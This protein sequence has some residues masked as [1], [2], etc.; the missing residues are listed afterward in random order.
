VYGK[1]RQMSDEQRSDRIEQD[2]GEEPDRVRETAIAY[3]EPFPWADVL[4]L[5]ANLATM[6]TAD[7]L[8]KAIARFIEPFGYE[9]GPPRYLVV[10]A[11]YLAK[12]GRLSLGDIARVT[13]ATT[14]NV[15]NLVDS[16]ERDGWLTRQASASDRRVT[17]VELTPEG[18]ERCG[19]LFPAVARFTSEL[20]SCLDQEEQEDLVSTL[21]KLR[22]AAER[23]LAGE[24]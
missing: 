3:L 9:L 7:T 14:T 2:A 8:R 15:T 19:R 12:D 16:L 23:H 13:G 11:V 24:I 1:G 4:A 20:F 22:R 21:L 10:R 5:E 6:E 17:Y 18:R